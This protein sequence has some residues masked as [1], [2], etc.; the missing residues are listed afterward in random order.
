MNDLKDILKDAARYRWLR[1]NM[2][3]FDE[4]AAFSVSV[5]LESVEIDRYI[6][7]ELAAAHE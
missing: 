4:D 1:E 7:A 3:R 5:Y 2:W 6:D